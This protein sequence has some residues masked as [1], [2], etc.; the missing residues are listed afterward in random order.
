MLACSY[1]FGS[2]GTP[3]THYNYD[4]LIGC[5][6]G[7]CMHIHVGTAEEEEE[8]EVVITLDTNRQQGNISKKNYQ[9]RWD[10]SHRSYARGQGRQPN[11]Q[12]LQKQ[13]MHITLAQ[14][15]CVHMRNEST[16]G[17]KVSASSP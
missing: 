4:E 15:V 5:N 2:S 6:D 14:N 12:G 1:G 16:Q 17:S 13:R 10:L 8:E 11:Q 9:R 7:Q 3:T